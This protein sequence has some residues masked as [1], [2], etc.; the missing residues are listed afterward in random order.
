MSINLTLI[1]Q[2]ITF[3]LFVFITMKYV[4]PHIEQAMKE[5]QAKIAE[6]LAKAEQASRDLE[7]AQHKA[8]EILREAK[9]KASQVIESGNKR[10]VEIVEQAKELARVEGKRL[11]DHA[12]ADIEKQANSVRRELMQ[13]VGVLAIEKSEKILKQSINPDMHRDILDTVT[14][15]I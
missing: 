2:M 7:L 14:E 13:G 1:G 15:E 10:S 3:A 9:L 6:G 12:Q 5:R 4:W 8:V 11:I